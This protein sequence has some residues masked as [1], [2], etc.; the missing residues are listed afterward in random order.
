MK[1]CRARL[2]RPLVPK[3]PIYPS[4]G[5]LAGCWLAVPLPPVCQSV[6]LS[7]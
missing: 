3:G 2:C 1:G 5:W 7:A 6:S 4:A